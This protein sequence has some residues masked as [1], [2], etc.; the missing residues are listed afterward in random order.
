MR[1]ARSSASSGSRAS[2]SSGLPLL[3]GALS[4]ARAAAPFASASWSALVEEVAES[5]ELSRPVRL[6]RGRARSMPM[7]AG[8]LHPAVLLP[9][10]AEAWPGEQRRAVLTHELGH[11]KRHDCLTQAL[12]HA[13]CA[14][15]WF[16]PLAWVAAWRLRVERERPATTSCCGRGRRP[17]YADQLL[18]LARGGRGSSGPVWAL[19]MARPSR[20]QG[21]LSRSSTLARAA[22]LAWHDRRHRGRRGAAGGRAGG[23]A[24]VGQAGLGQHHAGVRDAGR[25][26]ARDGAAAAHPTAVGPVG[27]IRAVAAASR[28]AARADAR[29]GSSGAR[30]GGVGDRRGRAQR[31]D[32]RR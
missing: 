6:L 17:D 12:A 26:R 16:H 5:T 8:L 15:Y 7:A 19:A 10:D 11:V 24:A 13:A 4:L 3:I 32:P 1:P 23:P 27:P 30:Q 18:Q 9:E 2:C 14:V 20:L 31:G 29:A 21:R 25:R 28:E 22:G